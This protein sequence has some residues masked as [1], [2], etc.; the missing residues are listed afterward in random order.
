MK[1]GLWYRPTQTELLAVVAVA[2]LA[3]LRRGELAGTLW[4]NYRGGHIHVTR[5][6]WERYVGNPKRREARLRFR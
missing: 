4:E 2:A 5:S 1:A 3:G 6:V